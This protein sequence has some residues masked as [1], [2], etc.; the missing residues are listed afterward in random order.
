MKNQRA[1]RVVNGYL[2]LSG[3]SDRPS[4]FDRVIIAVSLKA[5]FSPRTI[6]EW[7]YFLKHKS[8]ISPDKALQFR[9]DEN[10][11]F[12]GGI[13]WSVPTQLFTPTKIYIG[14]KASPLLALGFTVEVHLRSA[15]LT[16]E[17]K[18]DPSL[19]AGGLL[20]TTIEWHLFPNQ[21]RA[22]PNFKKNEIWE[23]GRRL[24]D[25]GEA[26]SAGQ[27]NRDPNEPSTSRE[28]IIKK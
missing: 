14:L 16:K 4:S 17:F 1:L 15:T 9:V 19:A 22:Q 2:C 25:E 8:P 28:A 6:R 7:E 20:Q 27:Q 12:V 24:L 23:T 3:P 10:H 26:L 11:W 13:T 21:Q 5:T 18:P